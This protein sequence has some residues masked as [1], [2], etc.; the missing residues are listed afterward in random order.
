MNVLRIDSKVMD[1]IIGEAIEHANAHDWVGKA[2]RSDKPSAELRKYFSPFCDRLMDTSEVCHA[3]SKDD[4][5]Q[6]RETFFKAFSETL[7]QNK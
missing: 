5:K 6:M 3:T 2:D 1:E 7:P 4:I